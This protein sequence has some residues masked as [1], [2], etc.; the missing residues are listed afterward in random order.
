MS[1]GATTTTELEVR[2][3]TVADAESCGRIFYEAFES[4][5]LPD[6]TCD[7]ASLFPW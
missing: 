2:E 6:F 4:I 3:V 5:V 7:V 1:A